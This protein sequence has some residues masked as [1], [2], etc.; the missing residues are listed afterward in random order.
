MTIFC[1]ALVALLL[2]AEDKAPAYFPRLG[3]ISYPHY[4]THPGIL[5]LAQLTPL[6]DLNRRADPLRALA[7][8]ILCVGAAALT[9]RLATA[10]TRRWPKGSANKSGRCNASTL[11]ISAWSL[12]GRQG[13]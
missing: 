13:S 1:P 8:I 10:S 6:F 12:P 5:A 4:V 3:D 11:E 2:R 9:A 7:V